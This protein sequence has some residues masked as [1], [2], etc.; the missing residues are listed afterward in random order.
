MTDAEIQ[1]IMESAGEKNTNTINYMEFIAA[2]MDK[3]KLL[4]DKQIANCFRMFDK[5]QKGKIGIEEFKAVFHLDNEV[6]EVNW[7][8]MVEPY[9]QNADGVIDFEEF[10]DFFRKLGQK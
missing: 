6:T 4:D 3:K 2:T 5:E 1:E 8:K 9:D 7:K 10:K